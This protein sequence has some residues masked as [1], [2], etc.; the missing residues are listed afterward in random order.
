MS[1]SCEW[2]VDF[3]FIIG[4]R[5]V[6]ML[7]RCESHGPPEGRVYKYLGKIEPKG[8]PDSALICGRDGC[9]ESAV[10]YLNIGEFE[11]Y[12]RQDRRI[13]R[14]QYSG[15]H[16]ELSDNSR[17]LQEWEDAQDGSDALDW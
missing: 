9:E 12:Q 7:F 13:Y 5:I 11:E 1:H 14:L 2:N 8:Y 15:H 16:I 3:Y 4:Y 17:Q 6:T 10:V